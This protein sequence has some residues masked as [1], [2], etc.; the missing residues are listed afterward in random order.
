M[1]GKINMDKDM[2][3]FI[4]QINKLESVK[5]AI[6][7][8]EIQTFSKLYVL[9]ITDKWILDVIDDIGGPI[10]ICNNCFRECLD[11]FEIS[12]RLNGYYGDTS[13]DMQ[14]KKLTE[15]TKPR[16]IQEL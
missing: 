11:Y 12:R 4:Q 9:S 3:A 6:C 8:E 14:I 7:K 16:T 5:C 1:K 10:I 15:N 13:F 2:K